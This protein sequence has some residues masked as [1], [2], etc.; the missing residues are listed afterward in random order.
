MG[1]HAINMCLFYVLQM[2]ML[3][4]SHLYLKIQR[5]EDPSSNQSSPIL[6]FPQALVLRSE[7]VLS[8]H[9]Q[10]TQDTSPHPA[11]EQRYVLSSAYHRAQS[12]P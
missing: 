1:C 4:A 6:P 10:Q 7:P 12:P 3:I 8:L 11:S 2:S 9:Q 5:H